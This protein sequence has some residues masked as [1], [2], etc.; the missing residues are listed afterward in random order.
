MSLYRRRIRSLNL[1]LYCSTGYTALHFRCQFDFFLTLDCFV[2]RPLYSGFPYTFHHL[3]FWNKIF[4]SLSHLNQ[5]Q[6]QNQN[7]IEKKSKSFLSLN[8]A[9]IL[10][11]LFKRMNLEDWLLLCFPQRVQRLNDLIWLVPFINLLSL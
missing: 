5:N 11:V 4:H 8:Q 7:T 10:L 9:V 2:F 6:F 3:L 1:F